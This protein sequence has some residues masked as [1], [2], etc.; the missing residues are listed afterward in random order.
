MEIKKLS[1]PLTKE[2]LSVLNAGD[3]VALTG[4]IYTARD[5]A[6]KRLIDMLNNNEKL[7]FDIENQTIFYAGPSPAKPNEVM[8]SIRPTTS[9]RMDAYSPR[10]LELGLLSMIGKGKEIK[11]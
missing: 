5:A 11:K 1:T 3:M 9:Y 7:P 4:T 2:K 8:G 10:L 6:H